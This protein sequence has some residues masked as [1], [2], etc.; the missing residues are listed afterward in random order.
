MRKTIGLECRA[1]QCSSVSVAVPAPSFFGVWFI[2]F[3]ALFSG[4]RL[5][6]YFG[7]VLYSKPSDRDHLL[8][9]RGSLE[10]LDDVGLPDPDLDFPQV[11]QRIG[12]HDD[13]ALAVS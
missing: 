11:R 1:L 6:G 7:L 3:V 9:F 13:N 8:P 10:H 2:G 4:T 12:A 5:Y